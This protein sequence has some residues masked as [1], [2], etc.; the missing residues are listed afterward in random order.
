MYWKIDCER[1]TEMPECEREGQFVVHRHETSDG[2]LVDLRLE[3]E[4]ALEGWRIEGDSLACGGL[5]TEKE[6]HSIKWLEDDGGAFRLD[7]GRYGWERHDGDGG[8]LI[9]FSAHPAR[10]TRV[11]VSRAADL[12]LPAARAIVDALGARGIEAEQA[13][14]LMVDGVMARQRATERLCGLGREL[15]ADAFD[16]AVWRKTLSTLTLDEIHG[17]LRS[18]ELRFDMK[19]PPLP[20]SRPDRATASSRSD[21]AL[22]IVRS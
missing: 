5:A 11:R 15:D 2:E 12:P 7:S 6:R 19:Y 22:A 10:A 17:Q 20:V 8:E 14:G 16:D 13:A 21:D 3:Y 9:L 4:G 18:F 1:L